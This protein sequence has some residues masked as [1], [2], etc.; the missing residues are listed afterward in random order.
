MTVFDVLTNLFTG[1]SRSTARVPAGLRV[2]AIGDIHGR[3]DLLGRLHRRILDDAG[4]APAGTRF[5]AVYLGDYVDRGEYSRQ[6]IDLLLDEPLAGFETVHL[7]GNHDESFLTFLDDESKGPSWFV[8]GG[9]AT[10]RSYG[11]SAPPEV[12]LNQ[13]LAH[14]QRAL[15]EAVPKR[16][17]A[18]LGR[19]ELTCTIGDYMFVH[20]G[21]RPGRRLDEQIPEDLLWIRDDFLASRADHG[22]V[23]VHG[24]SMSNRPQV[25]KNRIGID[26]GAYRTDVLTCLVLDGGTRRFLA[27]AGAPK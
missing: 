18:F 27:T 10:V 14:I 7:K 2:Y 25:R 9:D 17:R 1:G 20:A 6:V 3:V 19:L 4:A 16:H 15:R 8:Y 12:P 13:R 26:T 22:K 21:I 24:H 11:A 5:R 23:V